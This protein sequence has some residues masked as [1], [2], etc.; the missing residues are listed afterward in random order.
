MVTHKK[1]Q[2]EKASASRPPLTRGHINTWARAQTR[3]SLEGEMKKNRKKSEYLKEQEDQIEF[4]CGLAI[5]PMLWLLVCGV[6][7][8]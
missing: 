1:K 5:L 8:L 4:L 3:S 6:F 7:C 2:L